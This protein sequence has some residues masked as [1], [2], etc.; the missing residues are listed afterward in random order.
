[1]S[2]LQG[3]I[4]L[5]HL[6]PTLPL[7][8]SVPSFSGGV[9]NGRAPLGLWIKAISPLAAPLVLTVAPL[10]WLWTKVPYSVILYSSQHNG[11]PCLFA[12]VGGG[13]V[14]ELG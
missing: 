14:R 5:G 9:S 13:A 2:P 7:S 4:I 6:S 8:H 12:D 10:L 1:M 3:F 11:H